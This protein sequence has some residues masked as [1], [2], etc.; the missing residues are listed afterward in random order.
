MVLQPLVRN[1][2]RF[3][4]PLHSAAKG[5]VRILLSSD[6]CTVEPPNNGHVGDE[7]FFPLFRGSNMHTVVGRGHAVCPM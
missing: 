3:Q 7:C 5:D 6:T 1:L 2:Q 4:Q